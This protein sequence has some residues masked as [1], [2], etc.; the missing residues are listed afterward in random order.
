M[1]SRL[2]PLILLFSV[3]LPW[4]ALADGADEGAVLT[5]SL[6]Q[7]H[8]GDLSALLRLMSAAESTRFRNQDGA[9]RLRVLR[10]GLGPWLQVICTPASQE[11][12]PPLPSAAGFLLPPREF[13]CQ[14]RCQH[15]TYA[16][17]ATFSAADPLVVPRPRPGLLEGLVLASPLLDTRPYALTLPPGPCLAALFGL[18]LLLLLRGATR[19]QG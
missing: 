18:G 16:V 19:L 14:A 11:G 1:T 3:L 13:R 8:D 12:W 10:E 9:A 2:S 6:Q 15:G 7:A 17:L 4:P 5:W